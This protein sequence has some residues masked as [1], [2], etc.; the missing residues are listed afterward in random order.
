MSQETGGT[1]PRA[2][3]AP[4][5]APAPA[6]TPAKS[7]IGR[8]LSGFAASLSLGPGR[9]AETEAADVGTRLAHERTDLAIE[10]N[11]LAAERTLMAWIRTSLSMI[12]FG[13]TIGKIG[14]TLAGVR[15][16]GVFQGTRMIGVESIA[17][18]LVVLGTVALGGAILQYVGRVADY[19]A[20][21][22]QSRLSISV[23]VG[24]VLV[25][26]GGIALTALVLQL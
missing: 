20:M 23:I 14:Q 7:G 5:P 2:D 21:G 25:L 12:S 24:L 10:R 15:V 8:I 9:K 1:P 16:K 26:V 18:F 6:R 3:P 19:T 17:Y 13:F 4:S 11:Y 22:L